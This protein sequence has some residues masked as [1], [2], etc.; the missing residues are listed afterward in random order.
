MKEITWLR[1]TIKIDRDAGTQHTVMGRLG[2]I[3]Y[4]YPCDYGY[5]EGTIDGDGEGLDVF[6]GPDP[7]EAKYVWVAR[8]AGKDMETFEERKAFLG[9]PDLEA[10]IDTLR[11]RLANFTDFERMERWQFKELLDRL[12]PDKGCNLHGDCDEAERRAGKKLLH[13]SDE[14]CEDCVGC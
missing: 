11:G 12:T 7:M 9:F 2:P 1:W 4:T 3:P 10:C 6:I 14:D 13:Y 8:K 5:F